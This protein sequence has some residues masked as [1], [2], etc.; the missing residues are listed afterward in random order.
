MGCYRNF[1]SVIYCTAQNMV[2][3]SEETLLKQL[4][5]FQKY[6]GVDKVYLEPYRDGLMIPEAQLTML[7]RVFQENGIEVSGAL[8]TTCEDLSEGDQ[9]KQ[10]MGGTYCYTNKAMRDYLV[11]TVRYTARH[12]DEF[13]ID[14]WFFT[15]CTCEEC[16]KAKGN[17]SWEQFRT[18]LLVEVSKELIIKTAKEANPNCKVIIKYPNWSE[19]Y[20]ESGYDPDRQR[21]IFDKIYTGT[22]TRD[23]KH[24]DQ[25]LPKYNS[26]SLMRLMENYAPGRN[27][28]GW[29][30]PY[31]CTPMELYGEQAYLTALSRPKE[32]CQFCWGSLYQNRV[33]TP[34]GLQ[35]EYID[36]ML[37][38]A[39]DCRGVPCYLPP[40]AQGEDHLENFL[41][42]MGVPMEPTPD[43]PENSKS[44]FLT[45]QALRDPDIMEKLTRFVADGG[46]AIVTS[47]FMIGAQG[48]GIE[49][50]TSIRYRG[51][52]FTTDE[53][54]ED[55]MMAPTSLFSRQKLS[56]PVLEHRNNTTWAL[57]KGVAGE[58]NYPLVLR[59]SYGKGQLYTIAVPDM[60]G[61]L[62]ELPKEI[63]KVIRSLFAVDVSAYLDAP[64]QVSLFAYEKDIFAV[65]PYVNSLSRGRVSLIVKG[66]ADGLV[67]LKTGMT[68]KP[69]AVNPFGDATSTFPLMVQQGDIAF[70]RVVWNK[71]RE[72]FAVKKTVSSAPHDF[73]VS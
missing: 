39:G 7:K 34:I 54:I 2:N 57:C 25:H 50:M 67:D 11:K 18:D 21:Y 14:D 61:Y 32:I 10:R 22:E 8:T 6:C 45:V 16:R 58:E 20:Q 15:M 9:D 55:G 59:D 23:T 48:K 73:D 36:R 19:A 52:R 47:G 71:N 46:R 29:F 31:G 60:Y 37:D 30:D 70:Y 17:Q 35:L 49:E 1:K 43:F 51:R 63:L 68:I 53:F 69:T 44:V 13:I 41:G 26:Y 4:K 72:G 28:G 27:G 56:F 38:E 33:V 42:M 5:F 40:N 65:Y 3:M 66:V 62:Y 12:F 64:S 24:S